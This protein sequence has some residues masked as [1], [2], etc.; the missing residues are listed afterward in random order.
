MPERMGEYCLLLIKSREKYLEKGRNKR[1]PIILSIVLSTANKEWNATTTLIEK[2]KDN[3]YGFPKQKYPRY[4]VINNY[5]Y[6]ID[7]LIE[8][9]TGIGLVM[10]YE[11]VKNREELRYI[12][13]KQKEKGV[14]EREKN[15]MK[16]I[17][18]HIEEVMPSLAKK[19]TEEE[20]KE[21]KEEMRKIMEGSDFMTNFE[22]ALAR[23]MEENERKVRAEGKTDG[24]NQREVEIARE[25]ARDKIKDEKIMKYTHI[26]KKELEQL[27]LQMA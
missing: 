17:V 12:I 8:K 15:A 11:K 2:E 24:I 5:D 10:A 6:T 23:I 18:E 7:E 21:I 16:L 27:K 20:I 22:K 4:K 3:C 1:I 9:R 14:N 26:S 19:L 13:K 25:M